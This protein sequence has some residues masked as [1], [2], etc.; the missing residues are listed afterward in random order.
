MLRF[1]IYILKGI[2]CWTDENIVIAEHKLYSHA[3]SNIMYSS[4]RQ[5]PVS[6]T[7]ILKQI[8]VASICSF[9]FKFLSWS[10]QIVYRSNFLYISIFGSTLVISYITCKTAK[11]RLICE[12]WERDRVLR[13]AMYMLCWPMLITAIIIKFWNECNRKDVACFPVKI[14]Y[15]GHVLFL[16]LP[17]LYSVFCTVTLTSLLFWV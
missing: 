14:F 4:D 17:I 1:M 3:Q 9:L 6:N 2:G 10:A 8:S 15:I 7:R 11:K 16:E 5:K 12:N 13:T